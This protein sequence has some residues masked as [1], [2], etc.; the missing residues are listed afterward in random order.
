MENSQ[1]NLLE[2]L[3]DAAFEGLYIT[4][5]WDATRKNVIDPSVAVLKS[6]NM[7]CRAVI[8]VLI[9]RI[10]SSRNFVVFSASTMQLN[11]GKGLKTNKS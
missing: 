4:G 1:R 6:W 2:N 5:P 3:P 8:F 10:N 11:A 9:P 7:L